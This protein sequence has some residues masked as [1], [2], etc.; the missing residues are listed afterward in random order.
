MHDCLLSDLLLLLENAVFALQPVTLRLGLNFFRYNIRISAHYD[1]FVQRRHAD[2]KI[3][4]DLLACE[5]TRQGSRPLIL[6]ALVCLFLSSS[7]PS[8]QR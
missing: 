8:L 2:A 5:P 1:P 3:I 6:S 4:R 7:S